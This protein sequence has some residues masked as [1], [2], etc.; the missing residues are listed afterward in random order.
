MADDLFE[1]CIRGDSGAPSL[2]D[3]FLRLLLGLQQRDLADHREKL[4]AADRAMAGLGPTEEGPKHAVTS[5]ERARRIAVAAARWGALYA[6]STC[7]CKH[8]RW[9]NLREGRSP[10]ESAPAS[11]IVSF[12]HALSTFTAAAALVPDGT[13]SAL[14]MRS[15]PSVYMSAFGIVPNSRAEEA[16]VELSTG[17]FAFD[18]LYMLLY[19]RD[20]VF[21]VHHAITL[22][23][24]PDSLR[25]GR[26]SEIVVLA[27]LLGESTGICLNSWWLAKRGGNRALERPLSRLFT[28]AFLLMRV[29]LLPVLVVPFNKHAARGHYDGRLGKARARLW[30]VLFS[31]AITGSLIWAKALVQGLLKHAAAR[32][33]RR[34]L[35]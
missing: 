10:L 16:L 5:S 23:I 31:A 27:L 3:R 14:T 7:V 22:S 30:A 18:S 12:V 2:S 28:F 34:L 4:R 13:L 20:P 11:R 25:R 19:E 32:R 21:F 17:Y 33:A 26:G 1:R 29:G 15:S 9:L 24:W 8:S 6:A 35:Q